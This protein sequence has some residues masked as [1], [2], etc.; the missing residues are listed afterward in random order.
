MK[1]DFLGYD[2]GTEA[3]LESAHIVVGNNDADK[4]V[5]YAVETSVDNS[6]W[7]PAEGYAEYTGVET[8]KDVLNIDLKGVTARY[9]RIRSLETREKWV[10]F[11]E[12][13]VKQ[14]IDQAG[15]AENVYTNVK[16]HGMLGTTEAGM[17]SLQPGTI[18][19]KKRSVYRC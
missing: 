14:K 3:V 2:L 11:S 16:N 5:K 1:D 17:S 9:I 10:K 18:S 7:T 6:T 12:F 15:T 4:I 8:G 19:L 13:T